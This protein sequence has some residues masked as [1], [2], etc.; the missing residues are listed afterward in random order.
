MES[1]R[2]RD[3]RR[4][5]NLALA[6]LAFLGFLLGLQLAIIYLGREPFSD[7]RAYYDAAARLNAGLPL[8]EQPATTNEAAFYRYPPLLAIAFRPLALLPFEAAAL[9][10][11]V[12]VVAT[13]GLTLHRLGLARRETWLLVG[14]LGLPI[15][16]SLAIGQAQVPVTWLAILGT[17][18][19]IALAGQLKLLP[20]LIAIWWIGRR[21]WHAVGRF[22]AWTIALV[23]AQ[24]VL[25]P[26]GTL[27]YPATLGL[28][29]VGQVRNWSP[30]AI[31]PVLWAGLA[32]AGAVIVLRLAPGRYGWA[33]A[34]G[35]S[36]LATPR[37]L[38]YQ[39]MTFLAAGRRPR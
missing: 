36:I 12:V 28:E 37:L 33:A 15:G 17:P 31:S 16:W 5:A 22:V 6:A 8:Y 3:R 27:A 25:E 14:F 23:V 32:I 29:Q 19:S 1:S 7:V 21:D 9:L 35:L 30:Y 38:A 2:P 4:F 11:E 26:A 10:W 13:F 24:L 34:V 18:L 20:A 39:L